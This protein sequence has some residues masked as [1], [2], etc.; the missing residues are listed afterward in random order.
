MGFLWSFKLL[1]ALS[2]SIMST[3]FDV[4][5]KKE[6]LCSLCFEL[7]PQQM[8]QSKRKYMDLCQ[9]ANKHIKIKFNIMRVCS[10]VNINALYYTISGVSSSAITQCLYSVSVTINYAT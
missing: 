8:S 2:V 7:L 5:I 6:G 1:L 4:S 10:T 3:I 9:Q